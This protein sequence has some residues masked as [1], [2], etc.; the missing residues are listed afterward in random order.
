MRF[1]GDTAVRRQLVRAA[2]A[3]MLLV[4]ASGHV[5]DAVHAQAAARPAA[6]PDLAGVWTRGG[7]T[8][9]PNELPLNAR[10]VALREAID[11]SLAPMYDCVPATVPHI[12][13]DPYNFSSS[14]S[15]IA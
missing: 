11:E 14:S 10:G 7:R 13:G 9:A 5:A 15:A 6:A 12:L 1:A 3:A 8:T 4:A 2:M